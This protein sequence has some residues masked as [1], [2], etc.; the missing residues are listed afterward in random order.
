[1]MMRSRRGGREEQEEVVFVHNFAYSTGSSIKNY[2][3]K[4]VI[5]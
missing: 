4:S 3:D 5:M 1:M 2:F